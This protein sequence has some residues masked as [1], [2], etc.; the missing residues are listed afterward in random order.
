MVKPHRSSITGGVLLI[1]LGIVFFVFQ[2]SPNLWGWLN[3][4]TGWPL[5]VVAVGVVLLLF[6]IIGGVPGLAIPGSIVSGIGGILYWQNATGNFESWG[7]M[8]ALIPGF[9]G[10]GIILMGLLGEKR[11][12][13]IESGLWLVLISAVMFVVFA[14]FFGAVGIL[15]SYWPLILVLLGLL[16]LVRPFLG[17]AGHA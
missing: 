7:Y 5:I 14:S 17:R 13:S 15:G 4:E 11:R 6:G 9:V 8:W 2:L 12:E 1:L 16:L 10:I 3:V